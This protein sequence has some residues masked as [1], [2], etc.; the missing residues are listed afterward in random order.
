MGASG[1]FLVVEHQGASDP[2]RREGAGSNQ[3]TYLVSADVKPL[4]GLCN[5]Q[6]R[7]PL[8]LK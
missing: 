6:H 4:S 2:V 7:P 3:S 5:G 1:H 8:L